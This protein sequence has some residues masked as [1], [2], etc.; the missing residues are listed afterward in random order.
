MNYVIERADERERELKRIR[1]STRPAPLSLRQ[2][3]GIQ[4]HAI[5]WIGF[6]CVS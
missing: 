3:D 4:L 6:S 1:E 5:D 2:N